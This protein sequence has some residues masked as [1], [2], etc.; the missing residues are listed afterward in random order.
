M[1]GRALLSAASW[2]LSTIFL[3]ILL[4]AAAVGYS[5]IHRGISARDEPGAVEA[6]LARRM[7][8]WAISAKARALATRG[9]TR[10]KSSIRWRTRMTPCHSPQT[11]GKTLA[12]RIAS[13][14]ARASFRRWLKLSR[15][16]PRERISPFS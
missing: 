12:R 7:R 2:T 15:S 1:K 4:V 10:A 11:S 14:V 5:M 6:F 3:G 16:S 9:Q 13:S 8:H